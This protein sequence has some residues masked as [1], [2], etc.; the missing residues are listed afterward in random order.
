MVKI[1]AALALTALLVALGTAGTSQAALECNGAI[2]EVATPAGTFYVD[3]RGVDTA[4]V[5][6]YQETNGVAGLQSGGQ[7]LIL[8]DMD[9]D[10]CTDPDGPTPDQLIV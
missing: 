10:D 6:V 4:G 5:W 7:S 8:G 1:K 9:V 3:D 2:T